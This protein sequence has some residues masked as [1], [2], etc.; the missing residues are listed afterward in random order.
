MYRRRL[1]LHREAGSAAR[2]GETDGRDYH[3]LAA[4]EFERRVVA[5]EFLEHATYG[6]NRYGT[7][8]SEVD[9]IFRRGK[10]ALLDIEELQAYLGIGLTNTRRFG[11]GIAQV[12]VLGSTPRWRYSTVKQRM[13]ELEAENKK[14]A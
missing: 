11:A 1:E 8:R 2:P 9:A 6:G 4:A 3:F 10:H 5:G 14:G 13:A 7:L 12:R